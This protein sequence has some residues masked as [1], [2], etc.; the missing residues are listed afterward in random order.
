MWNKPL[1]LTWKK[2]LILIELDF[3]NYTHTHT[4]T[5][6]FLFFFLSIMYGGNKSYE[7]D[8]IQTCWIKN[9][10][11]MCVW[12]WHYMCPEN[13]GTQAGMIIS[14]VFSHC[15]YLLNNSNF[16]RFSAFSWDSLLSKSTYMIIW[17]RR[18][19]CRFF[20]SI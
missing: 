20:Y 12:A 3:E 13:A 9:F 16:T 4:H 7:K 10:I 18:R 14:C 6:A 15:Q 19:E 8:Y 11:H 5:V 2:Q 17:P 1:L